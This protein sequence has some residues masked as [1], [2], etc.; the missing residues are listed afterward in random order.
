MRKFKVFYIILLNIVFISFFIKNSQAQR[1]ISSINFPNIL[2]LLNQDIIMVAHDGIYY[3]NSDFTVE[4]T[5]KK[6]NFDRKI[7]DINDD[8]KTSIVQFSSEDDGYI[9]ILSLDI[10]YFLTNE[11]IF[12]GSEDLSSLINA[13]HYCIT[14][15]K[16]ENNNL[17]YIIT[18]PS[19][20]DNYKNFTIKYFV[21]DINNNLNE[22]IISKTIE[23]RVI[24]NNVIPYFFT[25]VSCLF[26]PHSSQDNNI[27]T[28]FYAVSF[29]IEI[30]S[31]SFDPKNNFEEINELFY[32]SYF[33]EQTSHINYIS[34][35]P[36]ENKQKIFIFYLASIPYYLTFD[37]EKKFSK[38]ISIQIEEE[39]NIMNQ[40]YYTRTFYFSQT[41]EIICALSYNFNCK[42]LI[43]VFNR[44]FTFKSMSVIIHNGEII[45]FNSFAY[46]I[47]FDG[48]NYNIIYDK[49]IPAEPFTFI[50]KITDLGANQ[51]SE[52]ITNFYSTSIYKKTDIIRTESFTENVKTDI[53]KT[54]SLTENS[55][56]DIIKTELLTENVK[57]DN[58]EIESSNQNLISDNTKSQTDTIIKCNIEEF[59]NKNE[60]CEINIKDSTLIKKIIINKIRE[61]LVNGKMESMLSNI[62]GNNTDL[63]TK[64]KNVLYEITTSYN[65]KNNNY[66]NISVI[67]LGKCEQ[68]LK[69]QYHLENDTKLLI[70]KIDDFEEGRLF[71]TIEYEIYEPIN[72]TK[73]DLNYCK[74]VKINISIPVS[75]DETSIY[76]YNL[77]DGY[78][79][80]K[81]YPTTSNTGTDIILS[82]RRNEY[83]NN[84][85][86]LCEENCN[87]IKYD[88]KSKKAICNCN[89]KT[90]INFFT[91]SIDKEKFFKNFIDIETIT[92]IYII[93]CYKLLFT[94]KGLI[95]NIGSY[96]ILFII[97]IHIIFLIIFLLKGYKSFMNPI[98]FLIKTKIKEDIKNKKNN[99]KINNSFPPIRKPKTINQKN[100]NTVSILKVDSNNISTKSKSSMK[101]I[102]NKNNIN[103]IKKNLNKK[104]LLISDKIEKRNI[105]KTE[106]IK[107]IKKDKIYEY[108]DFEIN[109][110]SYNKA[111]KKDKR[112]FLQCYL[113]L[114]KS[115]HIFIFTFFIYNDFNSSIIKICLFF[116][117]FAL[118]FTVNTL[119]F[120]DST[121]HKIYEEQGIYNIFYQ[122]PQILYSTLI[123]AFI[124]FIIKTLS[125]TEKN[126]LELK[127]TKK[128]RKKYFNKILKYI[129]IKF[130]FY[131]ILSFLLLFLFWYYISCF[132]AVYVNTQKYLIKDTLIS[133]G[134]SL[135]YPFIL[136]FIFGC[137]RICALNSKNKNKECLYKISQ[138]I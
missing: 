75:I 32:Y 69:Q 110:L 90:E 103:L 15:Y 137:L 104:I 40:Y 107:K 10:I 84:N 129:I 108:N 76:K 128:Y 102:H 131:F 73:L 26:L 77:S 16:K 133:F 60:I 114:I 121:M 80:D 14:P 126:V 48:A 57:N 64:E 78:Y 98:N 38:P 88:N 100:R 125:F 33:S 30:Q 71:P 79:N 20:D 52:S 106:S 101:L 81:C 9:V 68:I 124:N 55:K 37:F 23:I 59:F 34:I 138:I 56:I 44:D 92:N 27:L 2:T 21:Y 28:C 8:S 1:T 116:F 58:T 83:Y 6:I 112:T 41:D 63:I 86:S 49:G 51:L 17:H 135:L 22:Q 96:I 24:H 3:Y 91:E 85:M 39:Y 65:Q 117:C 11:G 70:L 127:N 94:K 12:I 87:F 99:S 31:K 67:H 42:K 132:C 122:I 72:K 89:I 74:N 4:D 97:L 47:F 95:K 7:T 136:Y 29:G 123:S 115:K 120:N 25:G 13:N 46:G 45:C 134:L 119:F 19:P 93:K 82:D 53:T 54:E 5:S 61:D 111:L 130:I 36:N 50:N 113:S 118:Y 43:I 35:V 105:R 18:Y 66:N 62:F 109:S